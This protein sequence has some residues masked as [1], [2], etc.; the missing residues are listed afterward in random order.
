MFQIYSAP[1]WFQINR[2]SLQGLVLASASPPSSVGWEHPSCS[3]RLISGFGGNQ[4]NSPP[5]CLAFASRKVGLCS[6]FSSVLYSWGSCPGHRGAMQMT[7]DLNGDGGRHKAQLERER[8]GGGERWRGRVGELS[9]WRGGGGRLL[10]ANLRK[11]NVRTDWNTKP[12]TGGPV[13]ETNN[14]QR[15]RPVMRFAENNRVRKYPTRSTTLW[16]Q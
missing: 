2:I 11:P 13:S 9:V 6:S 10:N 14:C 5:R 12:E 15:L 7:L 4:E 3:A 1:S 16:K 8:K